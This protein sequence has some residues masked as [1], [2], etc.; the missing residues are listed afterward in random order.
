[1]AAAA[2]DADFR[3]Q[4]A[5]WG[6]PTD[7]ITYLAAI[8]MLNPA[9]LANAA[10]SDEELMTE[11]SQPFIDGI[12][13]DGTM[14]K[15]DGIAVRW[16]SAVRQSW[17]EC[18]KLVFPPT[19]AAPAAAAPAAAEQAAPASR[20]RKSRKELEAGEFETNCLKWEQ[21][22]TQVKRTFPRELLRGADEAMA[23]V[24]WEKY[25][26]RTFTPPPLG[27]VIFSRTFMA[28]GRL[29]T[30]AA[31]P[32]VP[33]SDDEKEEKREPRKKYRE[34]RTT[35]CVLH[36]LDATKWLWI[37]AGLCDEASITVFCDYLKGLI[38]HGTGIG[39]V[40]QLYSILLWRVCAA[41]SRGETADQAL[42]ELMDPKN[43][44]VLQAELFELKNMPKDKPDEESKGRVT[45]RA[46]E[47]T[48]KKRKQ[49]DPYHVWHLEQKLKHYKDE[50][51]K[52]NQDQWRWN[53][54]GSS[55]SGAGDHAGGGRGKGGKNG[56]GTKSGGKGG[57]KG[58]KNGK[59]KGKHSSF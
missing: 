45:L 47:D 41:M 29:N 9:A 52:N 35:W 50:A 8:G 4:L 2:A 48:E 1:M 14:H 32:Y 28:D 16:R 19:P 37:W 6:V 5:G 49:P 40:K 23:R 43:K 7:G 24:L 27:E 39:I 21:Q 13:I 58:G 15:Y 25:I 20:P 54:A 26:T 34:P 17:N 18:C 33:A 44:T 51:K 11:V 57:G 10:V 3:N 36:A 12:N 38:E 31:D 46:N 55:S 59:G 42:N 56:K 30:S 22:F 53:P